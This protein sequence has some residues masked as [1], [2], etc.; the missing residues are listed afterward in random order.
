MGAETQ[1]NIAYKP[2]W[3]DA[4]GGRHFGCQFG[5]M[6]SQQIWLRKKPNGW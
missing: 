1:V 4:H 6:T 3:K 5:A 2:P